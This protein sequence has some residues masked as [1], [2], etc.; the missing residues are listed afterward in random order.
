MAGRTSL[1]G[2]DV[3]LVAGA[4]LQHLDRLSSSAAAS[5][6]FRVERG[7]PEN[8]ADVKAKRTLVLA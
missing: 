2:F 7:D 4:A 1:H 3:R 8:A 5:C 6:V